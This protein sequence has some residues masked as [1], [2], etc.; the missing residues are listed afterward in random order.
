MSK[1]KRTVVANGTVAADYGVFAAHVVIDG[2]RIVA[3]D[4]STTTRWPAPTR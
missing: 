4:R 3:V 2:E 1:G